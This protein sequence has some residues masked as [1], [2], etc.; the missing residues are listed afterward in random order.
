MIVVVCN[1]VLKSTFWI[2]KPVLF[3][4]KLSKTV[5]ILAA[6]AVINETCLSHTCFSLTLQ[7]DL[8]K[9]YWISLLNLLKIHLWKMAMQPK[10]CLKCHIWEWY[11]IKNNKPLLRNYGWLYGA[12]T[13][14]PSQKNWPG[15]W[16]FIGSRLRSGKESQF[17]ASLGPLGH[18]E[19][20][21]KNTIHPNL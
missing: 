9:S 14:Q 1:I 18:F 15:T 4:L 6:F 13:Y 19:D 8:R 20:L 16:L 2:K 11:L 3:F 17:L 7:W 10:L 5:N 21:N 12:K